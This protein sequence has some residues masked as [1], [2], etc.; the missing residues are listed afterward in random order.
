MDPIQG[1]DYGTYY[2]FRNLRLN[3]PLNLEPIMVFLNQLGNNPVLGILSLAV[4]LLVVNRGG[5]RAG[6]VFIANIVLAYLVVE[7]A[8]FLVDRPRPVEAEMD[9]LFSSSFPSGA[10]FLS[11]LVFAVLAMVLGAGTNRPGKR[12]AVYL[13]CLVPVL[14]MGAGS[15]YLCYHFL[16]DIL[17]GWVGGLFLALAGDMAGSFSLPGPAVFSGVAP[18]QSGK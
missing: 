16:T 18:E 4:L 1:I 7:G 9:G 13:G 6:I 2:W 12:C 17:A 11:C 15:L 10:A 14:A 3:G 5:N 8:K